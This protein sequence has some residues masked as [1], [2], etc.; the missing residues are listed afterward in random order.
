MLKQVALSFLNFYQKFLTVLGFGS[1][2]FYPTCSE[3]AKWQVEKNNFFKA[4]WF[5][6]LRILRCNQL[7][8]GGIDYPVIKMKRNLCKIALCNENKNSFIVK[9][10]LVPKNRDYYYVI[11]SFQKD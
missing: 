1:C 7:F 5:T 9:F 3:Y 6:A 11:K 10:W 4:I 8:D 2:R